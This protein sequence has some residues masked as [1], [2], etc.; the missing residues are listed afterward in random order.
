MTQ[1]SRPAAEPMRSGLPFLI[2]VTAFTTACAAAGPSAGPLTPVLSITISVELETPPRIPRDHIV[3]LAT[4]D[5]TEVAAVTDSRGA[6]TFRVAAGRDV[7][8]TIGDSIP[9]GGEAYP[10]AL[11]LESTYQFSLDSSAASFTE[12]PATPG[13]R[14][15]EVSAAGDRLNVRLFPRASELGEKLAALSAIPKMEFDGYDDMALELILADSAQLFA[16][17]R[18]ATDAPVKRVASD[19]SARVK[20]ELHWREYERGRLERDRKE[21]QQQEKEKREAL[22]MR[23]KPNCPNGFLSVDE[24]GELL[25]RDRDYLK[26]STAKGKCV[27]ELPMYEIRIDSDRSG[28]FQGPLGPPVFVRFTAP[29]RAGPYASFV[30]GIFLIEGGRDGVPALRAVETRLR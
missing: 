25:R 29:F 5:Q 20:S 27:V 9:T 4:V 17:T 14:S 23:A 24:F 13:R 21:L 22:L 7:L 30:V 18:F 10:R 28:Y 26:S 12:E 3:V 8:L 19:A 1:S 16:D 2:L 15:A 11:F 6:C